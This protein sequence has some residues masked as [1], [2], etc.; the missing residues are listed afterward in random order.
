M[1]P[2]LGGGRVSTHQ[3]RT[4]YR[5]GGMRTMTAKALLVLEDGSVFTGRPFG[6]SSRA[7]GEGVFSTPMTG[8]PESVPGI[9]GVDTRALTR[10]LRS[11]GVMM[12][13][14]TADET[15][16]EALARLRSAP[17]YG[18]SDPG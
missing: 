12:G 4:S 13:A 1:P 3:Q 9:A 5:H 8:Y 7:A 2:P 6:T 15:P 14:I 11:V 18:S 10:R 17:S 16:E